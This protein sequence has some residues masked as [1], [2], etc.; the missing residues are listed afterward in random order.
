MGACTMYSRRGR[1]ASAADS[2]P[3]TI[4][5][6]THA[7]RHPPG[8]R[9]DRILRGAPP[10]GRGRGRPQRPRG[11]TGGGGEGVESSHG[12]PRGAKM[13]RSEAGTHVSQQS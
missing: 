12:A 11:E 5:Q 3:P 6:A 1:K 9:G 10:A 8:D 2:A 13:N 7:E 4:R